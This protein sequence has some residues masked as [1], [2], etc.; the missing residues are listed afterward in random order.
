MQTK[1]TSGTV[2]VF[3]VIAGSLAQELERG[4]GLHP[5]ELVA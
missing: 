5:Q 1:G 4:G 2:R 3:N